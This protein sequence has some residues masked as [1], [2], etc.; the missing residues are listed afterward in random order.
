MINN[1][2]Q[3]GRPHEQ[4]IGEESP[5]VM[6]DTKMIIGA[7]MLRTRQR[8]SPSGSETENNLHSTLGTASPSIKNLSDLIPLK[9]LRN[10]IRVVHQQ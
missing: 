8:R 6:I 5:S 2:R 4:A 7:S 9:V 3:S 1:A 10:A